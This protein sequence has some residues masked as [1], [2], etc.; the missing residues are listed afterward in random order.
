MQEQQ[1]QDRQSGRNTHNQVGLFINPVG[2]RR[3]HFQSV[4][5]EQFARLYLADGIEQAALLLAQQNVDLL[6]ID[7]EQFD[8][9]FD[10]EALGKLMTQ[11]AG[12]ATLVLCPFASAAWLP[13]LM[14]YGPLAYAIAPVPDEQL[15]AAVMAPAGLSDAPAVPLQSLLDTGALLQQAVAEVDNLEKMAERVCAA[16]GSLPG[17]VHASLFHIRDGGDL[18]LEA[19]H[20]TNGLNLARL[21]TRSDRLMQSPLRLAFPGLLA[22]VT[23][24][25]ALLDAP[26]KCGEPELALALIESRVALVLGLRLPVSRAGAQRGALCLMFDAA[27]VFSAADLNAFAGYAQLAGLGLRVA[28]MSRENEHL[29]GRLTQMST[30]DAL[31]GIVNRRHGE[32][33]LELEVRRAQRYKVPLSLIVFDIDRFKAINDQYGH[34]VGDVVIRAVSEATQAT[35]RN[36]DVL[37]R[38]GGEEFQIIAPHTS[39]IDALKIAEKIRV[40]IAATDI[41]GCDRVTISMGVGQATAQETP[42]GLSVR[43]DAALAR[44]KR[45]GRN[46]VELAMS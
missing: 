16:L 19:Q 43:V 24:E 34:P 5:G 29:L 14:A 23:G 40:A 20:A 15:R 46:C 36:S 21:L 25:I 7:L 33:L 31:T 32:Y 8:Q 38:S 22:A 17:V 1:Q 9:S 6:V 45:A 2:Q 41:P 3:V 44:A 10:V 28:E 39:A 4:C 42:D 12:A 26:A 11:R 37:V 35:V 18:H 30:T 13:A 27:R